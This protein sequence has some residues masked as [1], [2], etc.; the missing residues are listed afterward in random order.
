[1]SAAKR[2]LA[3]EG[4]EGLAPVDHRQISSA[5]K[6]SNSFA[7]EERER[8]GARERERGRAKS[9]SRC[10]QVRDFALAEQLVEEPLWEGRK[11]MIFGSCS[12]LRRIISLHGRGLGLRGDGSGFCSHQL[13]W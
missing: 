5:E 3:R 10:V 12:E 2:K 13:R 4:L 1:M 8:E 11:S 9:K 7:R 6:D